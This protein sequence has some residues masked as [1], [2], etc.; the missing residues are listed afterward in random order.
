MTPRRPA[1]AFFPGLLGLIVALVAWV[2]APLG[3]AR[4]LAEP[5]IALG[6]MSIG[7]PEAKVTIIEYA[8][9]SCPHCANFHATVLPRLQEDYIGTGRVRLIHR[10]VFF[11]RSSF[12]AALVARCAGPERYFGIAGLIYQGQEGWARAADPVA[13]ADALR[14]IGLV[15]G[16]EAERVDACMRDAEGAQ[17]LYDRAEADVKADAVE[18]TPTLIV[19]GTKHR[20]MPYEELRAVIDA[21][22]AE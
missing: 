17:A 15:A 4:A 18:A 2:G 9:F 6:D 1:P 22:L 21:A 14:R 3:P 12:W 8:S 19:N 20:N 10:E 5:V 16:L 7:D 11:D 13:A